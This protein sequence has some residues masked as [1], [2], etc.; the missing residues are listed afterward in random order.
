MYIGIDLGTSS[1]KLLVIRVS[2]E[3]VY[4]C[5]REYLV[6]YPKPLWA[7]QNPKDWWECT[8]ECLKEVVTNVNSQE[9]KAIGL[10]GQMHGLVSLDKYGDILYPTMLWCDQRT[11]SECD[12]ITDYFGKEKLS[13]LVGNKALTG[14]TAPKILWMKKNKLELFSEMEMILLPKDYIRYCLT[15]NYATDV[16]DASGM[17]LLDIKNR[18]YSDEMLN[19]IGITRSQLPKLYES[20]EV[21]GKLSDEMK[22]LLELEQDVIVVAGAGDQAAGAIGSG[23]VTP[24]VVSVTLGTS[25]VVFAAHNEYKVDKHNRLHSFCHANG[26]Y[27]S[28]GVMLSAASCLKWWQEVNG[29]SIETL[30]EELDDQPTEVLF[31]PYLLGERTPYSDPNAKACFVGM[32]ITTER[33]NLTKSVLEG[34][35]FGL[36]DSFDLLEE[37]KLP[38]SEVRILGGGANSKLWKQIIADVLGKKVYDINT[39]QGSSLGAAILAT[40]GDGEFDNVTKAV[41]KIIKPTTSYEPDTQRHRDYLLKHKKFVKLYSLLKDVM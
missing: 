13:D 18:K 10:S 12:E 36:K 37:M 17:L 6:S 31:L 24:G 27:H 30:L 11:Q 16:S 5:S 22:T 1:V 41:N 28:M 23:V 9:I 14:F 21:T 38:V 34:V 25:G 32:T 35:A 33:K 15:G 3:I 26:N 2:G 20:Y 29:T 40:V 4:E 39:N 19:M 8:L 7:E